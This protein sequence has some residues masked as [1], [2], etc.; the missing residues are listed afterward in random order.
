MSFNSWVFVPFFLA[1]YGGYLLL[2]GRL[3]WQN[4]W[5][6]ACSLFFYG[7]WDW[8]FVFLML[9][10]A[11]VDFYSARRKALW[12][13]LAANL[14]ALGFFKYYDLFASTAGAPLLRIALPLGISFYTFHALSYT[15]DVCTGKAQPCERLEDFLL[16]ICFFPQLVAGPIARADSLLPQL[17]RPRRVTGELIESG[18]ALVLWGYL[19][20]LV[21]ADNLA[22]FADAVFRQPARF[23]RLDVLLG[24]IAFFFQ[25]YADFSGYCDIARGLGKLMGIE[26]VENFDAPLLALTPRDFWRKW[27]ISLS[28]WLRD[29]LY[30]PLGGSRAGEWT[31]ARNVMI[32][33]VLGGLWHGASWHF[34]A[35]GAYEGLLLLFSR[36]VEEPLMPS[37]EGR[38]F[39]RAARTAFTFLR[40][41]VGVVIFRAPT[42]G[43][44]A[45]VLLGWGLTPDAL[46][47]SFARALAYFAVP[48]LA[49]EIA[50]ECGARELWRRLEGSLPRAVVY[51]A[52]AALLVVLANR[53][54]VA[55]I[56]F[57]F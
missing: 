33:M 38:P 29:Y 15:I 12:V 24:S 21:I 14:G 41:L 53:T 9:G 48:L 54:V 37:A 46:T 25:V 34:A 10:T 18:V 39:V 50:Q 20:K 6:L 13:S 19:K 42:V 44:A 8:R 23:G 36:W 11:I 55:F 31:T 27:N 43:A 22:P 16:F 49:F 51:A 56:Y 5:L 26:L 28:S 17:E 32:V 2:Q 40:E 30:F 52:L 35:W 4:R 3:R 7:W 1:A 47:G 57:Q 45:A